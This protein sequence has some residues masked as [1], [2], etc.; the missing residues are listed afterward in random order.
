[1]SQPPEI[2]VV[3]SIN[4]DLSIDVERFPNPGETVLGR[5]LAR[6]GG[7]KG[8]NQA[9][10]AARLGRR[11]AMVGRVGDDAD[12]TSLAAALTHEG[13]DM[14]AVRVA[15]SS[16]TGLALIEV[17][18]SGENRIVVVPGANA[19]VEPADLEAA[20]DRLDQAAVI[21]A[22]LEVPVEVVEALAA[23]P[24]NGRLILN[25]APAVGVALAGIDLVVPNRSEL[26]VLAGEAE[27]ASIDEVVDQL[28]SLAD[29]PPAAVVTLGSDGAL[30]VDGL[31]SASPS[32][33]L[34]P[35]V[36]VAVVDTTGAGDAFCGGMADAL[37]LG[38][39][40]LEAARWATRVAA[41]AVTRPGAWSALPR[42]A[43]L[44]A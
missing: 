41:V 8:A 15:E 21:L 10:A 30:V 12:G 13:I 42:R 14:S 35:A 1:M 43:E 2:A 6:G 17:D 20:A 22:Q 44:L 36:E 33:E 18:P 24:R 16:P 9:V 37:C 11:V 32:V 31:G 27:A 26:A 3:G 39:D 4:L 25:P 19:T 40:L 34:V 5:G 23:R 28:G 7:G 29:G 38:A